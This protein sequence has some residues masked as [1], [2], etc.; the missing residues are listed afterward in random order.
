MTRGTFHEQVVA[1]LGGSSG[2]GRFCALDLAGRGTK[3]LADIP[4][5]PASARLVERALDT[6]GRLDSVIVMPDPG[7]EPPADAG[8]MEDTVAWLAE[9]LALQIGTAREALGHFRA[10]G[11][12]RL[13]LVT[14]G[15]GIFGHPDQLVRAAADS[16]T[17]GLLRSL[18]LQADGARVRV[19]AVAPIVNVAPYDSAIRERPW[20]D[21]AMYD[22]RYAL[23]ALAYLA[24][25]SCAVHGAVLSAGGGRFARVATVTYAGLFDPRATCESLAEKVNRIMGDQ[26]PMEPHSA[27]DELLLIEV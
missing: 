20:V 25:S 3:V 4:G 22:P 2:L 9:R 11:H 23:P 10:V 5:E 16:A 12:G 17:I 18:A 7:E 21:P 14:S 1:V 26:Y 27:A 19:N 13:V 6:H 24:H 15:S 8:R